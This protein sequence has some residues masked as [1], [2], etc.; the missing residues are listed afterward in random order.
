MPEDSISGREAFQRYI[1]HTLPFLQESGGEINFLG[2]GGKYFIG[3][4][5]EKWDLAMLIRQSSLGGFMEF[6]SNDAYI[7]GLGH[8]NAAIIDS[9]LLPLVEHQNHDII[10]P[11]RESEK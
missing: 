2:E 6:A 3:P 5:A 4:D 1:N 10:S 7:A 8:R 11:S 9:R